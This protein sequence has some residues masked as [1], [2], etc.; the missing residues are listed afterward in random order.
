MDLAI[1]YFAWEVSARS[2]SHLFLAISPFLVEAMQGPEGSLMERQEEVERIS[3]MPV[4]R[5]LVPSV[6][7]GA[8]VLVISVMR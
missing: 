4:M 5:L 2:V 1:L 7:V 8:T 3:V 6:E